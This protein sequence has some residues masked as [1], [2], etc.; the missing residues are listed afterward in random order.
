MPQLAAGWM[1]LGNGGLERTEPKE[2]I[3][4]NFNARFSVTSN[5]NHSIAPRTDVIVLASLV[6]SGC[7]NNVLARRLI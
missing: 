7:L 4:V 6:I 1:M 3:D 2:Q 5:Q